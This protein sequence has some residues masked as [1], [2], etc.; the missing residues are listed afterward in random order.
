MNF[1]ET[2]VN[3]TLCCMSGKV[4]MIIGTHGIGKS[5]LCKAVRKMWVELQNSHLDGEDPLT[6]DDIKIVTLFGSL[7]KE[8]ELGGIPVPSTETVNG[9]RRVINDYTTHV[10]LQEI[11]DNDEA[12]YITILFIDEL[13]RSE[14]AVQQELMQL[15][16]DKQ[17][18]QTKLPDSCVIICAGNPETDDFNDYQVNIMNAALKNR[19]VFFTMDSNPSEWLRWGGLRKENND[20]E[21]NINDDILEFIAEN[22]N[23]LNAV[24]STD[25][26]KP[27]PRGVAMFSDIYNNINLFISPD[28]REDLY[29]SEASGI[30]GKLWA[31]TFV[32]F[33][34]NKENPLVTVEEIF[35]STDKDFEA[36]C[37]KAKKESPL[38]QGLIIDRSMKYLSENIKKIT[39]DKKSSKLHQERFNS[40]LS[41]VP[42]DLM[43]GSMKNMKKNY[44]D[45]FNFML[46][47]EPFMDLY[48]EANKMAT[49][50]AKK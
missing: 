31:T 13:N 48:F 40:V 29:F 33:I 4:P 18:N 35:A 17:I 39:K 1:S 24:R 12:G 20:D 15:I 2:V 26:I 50:V 49:S 27:T 8:G 3:A 37:D 22:P 19:M 34:R 36:V 44:E 6:E 11:L 41:V 5:Q 30:C 23:M 28:E 46:D 42:K 47:Y 9:V 21:Q 7:L 25:D 32:S 10:R 45:S 43:V 38:R 16:L 14:N